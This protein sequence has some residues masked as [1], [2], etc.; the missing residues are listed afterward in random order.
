V[1]R[2]PA[3]R[4]LDVEYA[5]RW[6]YRDELPKRHHGGSS[7][8]AGTPL[9][10][11]R[12]NF[13]DI[14]EYF[15][16]EPGF[17]E[18][19]GEPH[20]DAFLIEAA[21]KGL[22]AWKGHGFG[23]D[24]AQSGLMHGIDHM[25]I[26]HVQAGMEAVAAMAGIVSV[27]ARAATRPRWSR[28]LPEPFPDNGQN[29]KPRVLIDETFVEMVDRKGVYYEP[30]RDPEP[31]AITFIK[32]VPSPPIRAG[33]YRQGAYCPLVYRPSPAGVVA[34]RAEYAAW[35]MGLEILAGEL[36]GRLATIG[37][38]TP[39]A[40][41]RPWCFDRGSAGESEQHGRPPE[42]FRGQRDEPHRRVTREQEASRRRAAQ[43]RRL[44]PRTEETRPTR[45][46]PTG[47]RDNGTDGP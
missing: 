28:K 16:R 27:N 12:V 36:D 23:P 19:A 17:P 2:A 32:A 34:Q 10:P 44:E 4:F 3:K 25:D 35:R 13:S 24:P 26:D 40:P 29:G 33:L 31:G 7:W 11:V 38:L 6:A 43:R 15:R 46:S 42:L 9:T 14:G 21:A 5:L 20:P 8:I 37:V 39:A 30:T 1:S 18:A 47:R 41:W 45:A 22:E